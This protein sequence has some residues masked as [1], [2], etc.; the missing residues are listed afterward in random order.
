ME[1]NCGVCGASERRPVRRIRG[2]WIEQCLHCGL[3]YT[4]P[5][6]LWDYQFSIIPV[7]Q[8]LAIYERHYWPKRRASVDRFWGQAEVFRQTS[9]LLDVG[10][11][12]GFFPNEARAHGWDA[13]GLEVAADEA[14]WGR[15]HFNLPIVSS[16]ED[17][18]LG[19]QSFDIITLWDVI[20]HIVDVHALLLR[21][22]KL[23]RPGGLLFLR[24]PNA[25]GLLIKPRW[26]SAAY[27][28]SYWQ[29]VYPAN[30]IEHIYHFTPTV[31][32]KTLQE[33]NFTIRTIETEQDWQERILVGRNL[34]VGVL[35]RFLMWIAWKTRLPY[36]MVV[37]AEKK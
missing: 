25:D 2:L 14:A 23:L 12:F 24:T 13:I 15:N 31:L 21:C 1:V 26:W 34:L 18:I 33:H 3:L 22:M 28:F 37:W 10:C 7:A 5:R 6:Y 36:E 30:P 17:K 35:R 32:S 9:R 11:G 4:N 29:L 27:L 8:K 19:R 16:L 20:E